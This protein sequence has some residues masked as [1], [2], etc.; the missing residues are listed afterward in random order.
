MKKLLYFSAPWCSPCI[1]MEPTIKKFINDNSQ[2]VEI[3]KYNVD[4][5]KLEADRYNISTI[6]TFLL[7][8]ERGVEIP[9][10][11]INGAVPAIM[12]EKLI[13]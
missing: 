10:K 13:S 7:V 9:G 3:H 6:P 5:N 8:D 1:M 4:I 12:L 11:R 2:K